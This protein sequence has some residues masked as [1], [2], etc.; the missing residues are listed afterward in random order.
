MGGGGGGDEGGNDRDNE[1]DGG[2]EDNEQDEEL[3]ELKQ[4]IADRKATAQNSNMEEEA[5]DTEYTKAFLKSRY[6]GSLQPKKPAIIMTQPRANESRNP[7]A[8][9]MTV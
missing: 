4:F 7:L 6:S 5:N 9:K 2:N 3:L 1:D 8:V